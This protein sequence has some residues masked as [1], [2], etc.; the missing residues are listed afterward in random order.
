VAYLRDHGIHTGLLV[1]PTKIPEWALDSAGYGA[2]YYKLIL[3]RERSLEE[4]KNM[5]DSSDLRQQ[6][7]KLLPVSK[8]FEE[9]A[10]R[11]KLRMLVS[12]AIAAIIIK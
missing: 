9:T 7:T 4:L 12:S 8:T 1:I 2:A 10:A 11:D 3:D 6:A 5:C